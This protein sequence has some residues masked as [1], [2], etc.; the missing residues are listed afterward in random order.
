ME[1][2][3]KKTKVSKN[4]LGVGRLSAVIIN[5]I[6]I[7][8]AL[9]CLTPLILI[10]S[11]SFSEEIDIIK[12]GFRIIPMNFTTTAYSVI[13]KNLYKLINAYKVT[14]TVTSIGTVASL[15][16]MSMFAYTLSR[17]DYKYRR[18]LSFY[19]FFTMMFS[20]GLV[21]WYILITRYLKLT[22]TI[23]VLII[24]YLVSAW[25]LFLLRTYFQKIPVS[26][27]EAA[28]IDG[29]SEFRIYA[30]LI[31][32]LSTPGLAT[33]GMFV[34]LNYWNDWWL[35][36]LFINKTELYSL[37]MLLKVMMDNIDYLKSDISRLFGQEM[38]KSMEPPSETTRMAMCL[39]AIG[40][41]MIL[42]PFLQKY[43]VRG[44]TIGSI[45][46]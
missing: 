31:M 35:S 37:Q 23:S 16:I 24:P 30:Q 25:N 17:R 4:L 3:M 15:L 46:G 21:P 19:L 27:I 39:L 36:L 6:M 2:T 42:F 1:D 40:P 5:L 28:K 18:M 22:D 29:A 45:K 11:I 10:I 44:L 14:L 34:A 20:G 13:F 43:F 8:M 26:L 38:L 7:L 12:Y 33:V 9:A 41:I 32:P